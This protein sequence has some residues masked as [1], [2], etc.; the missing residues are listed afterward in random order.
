M[1]HCCYVEIAL[2]F[3][4]VFAYDRMQIIELRVN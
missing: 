4:V 3:Q 2:H 1:A